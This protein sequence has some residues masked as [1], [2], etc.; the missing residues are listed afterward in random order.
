VVE[1]A[2]ITLP[3]VSVSVTFG[4]LFGRV[5]MVTLP[6]NSNYRLKNGTWLVVELAMPNRTP[7][8]RVIITGSSW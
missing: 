6:L 1:L 4:L 2:S 8:S 3:V 5:E 7:S